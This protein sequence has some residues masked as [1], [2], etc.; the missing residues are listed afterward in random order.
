VLC[1]GTIEVLNRDVRF[2]NPK[3]PNDSLCGLH[4][5]EVAHRFFQDVTYR[6]GVSEDLHYVIFDLQ[7]KY[8]TLLFNIKRTGNDF[9]WNY[10]ALAIREDVIFVCNQMN[11]T[12]LV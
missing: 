1:N 10:S 7:D 2:E 12:V 6:D 4:C 9:S 5:V 8:D 11:K 3:Y